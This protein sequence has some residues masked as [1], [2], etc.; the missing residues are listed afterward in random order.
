MKTRPLVGELESIK[1]KT[2][3]KTEII[4]SP[5]ISV[6]DLVCIEG[7]KVHNLI[8]NACLRE[9]KIKEWRQNQMRIFKQ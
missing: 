7:K 1:S 5:G 3:Y 2:S 9:N 4:S 8:K 6:V